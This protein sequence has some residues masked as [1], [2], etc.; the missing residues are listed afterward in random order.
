VGGNVLHG[1]VSLFPASFFFHPH[2]N[3][4]SRKLATSAICVVQNLFHFFHD[5][6]FCC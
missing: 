3:L 1:V 2:M 6:A 5:H 4:D